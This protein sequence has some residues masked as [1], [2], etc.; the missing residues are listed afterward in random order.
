MNISAKALYGYMFLFLQGKY[1]EVAIPSKWWSH[2]LHIFALCV[3][4]NFSP[5]NRRNGILLWF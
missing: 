5:S 2:L 1:L 3:F 4:V